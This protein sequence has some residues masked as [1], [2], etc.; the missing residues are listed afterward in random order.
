MASMQEPFD[1][2]RP[3]ESVTFGLI[4]LSIF[5][6]WLALYLDG[7]SWPTIGINLAVWF[8]LF[9]IGTLGAIIHAIVCLC[10]TDKH[11]KYSNPARRRLRYPNNYSA[12]PKVY[13]E[14]K[15]SDSELLLAPV[16]RAVIE[17]SPTP[18]MRAVTAGPTLVER[19]PTE[20]P[21]P[22]ARAATAGPDL[23][24]RVPTEPPNPLQRSA[25]E[26]PLMKSSATSSST[27]L[28]SSD[29]EKENPLA[30]APRPKRRHNPFKD[31]DV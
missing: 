3:K 27:S 15:I 25:S 9:P 1:V 14:K 29:V 11:R 13:T 10:R 18:V 6:P 20:P 30:A 12:R 19:V 16:S 26:P 28:S 21:A 31:P 7:A 5:M 2:P 17:P 4:V 24:E 8:F 23:L 22:V